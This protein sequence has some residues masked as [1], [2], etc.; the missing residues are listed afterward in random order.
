M[1]VDRELAKGIINLDSNMKPVLTKLL[2]TGFGLFA[3]LSAVFPAAG[4]TWMRTSAPITNINWSSVATSADGNQI[5]AVAQTPALAGP[6]YI[7]SDAGNTW[8]SNA[9]PLKTWIA[10]AASADGSKLVS[11]NRGGTTYAST[12]SGTS[13]TSSGTS[14][15]WYS[16]G[17]SADGVTLVAAA[18]SGSLYTSTNSGNSWSAVAGTSG[19]NWRAV[20]G[21]ADGVKWVAVNQRSLGG[22]IYTSTNSGNSWVSNNAPSLGFVAAAS[23]VDGKVL[24]AAPG[25]YNLGNGPICISTNYGA[26]WFSNTSPVLTWTA[27][28]SSADGKK[29]VATALKA[30]GSTTFSNS[31]YTSTN[32]GATWNSNTVPA[33]NWSAV[34]TSADGKKLVA[35]TIWGGIWTCQTTPAPQLNLVPSPGGLTLKW[36]VPAGNFVLQQ[37]TDLI[38]WLDLTNPPGLNYTNLQNQVILSPANGCVF[39]RLKTP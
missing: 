6:I 12:N 32:Y 26:T 7:S 27:I 11:L 1:I 39:Y 14:A 34:A 5:V 30:D 35:V 19:I 18:G 31:I 24:A 9:L 23:S 25:G 16:V 38:A 20:A 17:A 13:W 3:V 21:S 22:S 28:A 8:I 15:N 10:V 4:Q 29:L 33:A 36:P 2:F 37:S